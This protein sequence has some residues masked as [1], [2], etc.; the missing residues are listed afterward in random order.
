MLYGKERTANAT[1]FFKIHSYF[2]QK[3]GYPLG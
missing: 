1:D 3:Q 2:L